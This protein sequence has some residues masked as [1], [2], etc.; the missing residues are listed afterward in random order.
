MDK[1]K[2]LADS[3]ALHS[4]MEVDDI[5]KIDLYIDQVMQLFETNFAETKRH[6]E[7]KILTKTMINNYAKGKLF[8]PI[9]NKKYS[10]NHVMLI[11][12]I[13]QMKNILSI[14]DVK[15]TLEGVNDRALQQ[16]GKLEEFYRS[17]LEVQEGN[18]DIFTKGLSQQTELAA[19]VLPQGENDPEMEQVL[20]IASF[21]HMSKLYKKAAEKLIDNLQKEEES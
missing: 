11:N 16:E 20:L 19:T 18:I 5:P 21:A 7:E 15:K 12:L 8:Y 1:A 2:D 14:S 17:Y 9:N 13:Y 3:L 10:R 6:E 4:R